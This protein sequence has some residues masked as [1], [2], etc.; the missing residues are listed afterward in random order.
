MTRL[1][2]RFFSLFLMG[3]ILLVACGTGN[4]TLS[5][6]VQQQIGQTMQAAVAANVQQTMQAAG[7]VSQQTLQ[8]AAANA[9]QTVQA[10]GENAQQT[11]QAAAPVAQAQPTNTPVPPAAPAATQLPVSTP[12]SGGSSP[13]AHVNKNTNCRSGPSNAYPLVFTA[14]AGVDLSIV[15]KTS[16]GT[17]VVVEN[18]NNSAQ[19]CW[20]FTQYVDVNGNLSNLPVETPL[21]QPTSAV[22]FT[23]TFLHL[24]ECSGFSPAFKVVNSGSVTLNSYEIVVRDQTSKTTETD[25]S[26]VFDKRDG[27]HVAKSITHLDPGDTGYAYADTFSYDPNDHSMILDL[28]ICSHKN[29]AGTCSEL[30]LDFVP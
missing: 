22:A 2:Y 17:Y 8:A 23:V 19:T 6:E 11:L 29:L 14:L 3:S 12:I 10:A 18:P 27:C 5:V 13:S 24:E 9:Q 21:P 28:T 30:F 16:N 1:P 15:S 26:D 7:L 25:H 20:L 4:P